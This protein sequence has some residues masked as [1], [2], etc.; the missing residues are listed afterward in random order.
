[1]MEKGRPSSPHQKQH[2]PG[3]HQAM[4]E[5]GRLPS[6]NRKQHA[7]SFHQ[8]IM[9]KSWPPSPHKGFGDGGYGEEAEEGMIPQDE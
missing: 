3:F 8:A 4:T 7:P 2:A 9:E 6:P 1:M 5:K